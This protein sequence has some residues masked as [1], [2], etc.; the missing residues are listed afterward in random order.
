MFSSVSAARTATPSDT[1]PSS[2]KRRPEVTDTSRFEPAT[3][4]REIEPVVRRRDGLAG[5]AASATRAVSG[6]RPSESARGSRAATARSAASRRNAS[7]SVTTESAGALSWSTP[8]AS[9]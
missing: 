9:V 8:S 1:S 6:A 2:C 5:A 4:P 7:A 3:T